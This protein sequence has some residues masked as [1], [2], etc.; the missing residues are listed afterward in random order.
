MDIL[1]LNIDTMTKLADTLRQKGGTFSQFDGVIYELIEAG[2]FEAESGNF[3]RAVWNGDE[4]ADC[5]DCQEPS[6]DLNSHGDS[7]LVMC[8]C[9]YGEAVN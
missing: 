6:A 3:G 7:G 8:P 5:D 1:E 4:I 2:L 9:C